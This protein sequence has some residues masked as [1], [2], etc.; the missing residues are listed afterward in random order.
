MENIQ[1]II[2]MSH[3][4]N[5]H[6]KTNKLEEPEIIKGAISPNIQK[7]SSLTRMINFSKPFPQLAVNNWQAARISVEDKIFQKTTSPAEDDSTDAK[8]LQG[9]INNH[10]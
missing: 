1:Q 4:E 10:Q 5:N 3:R 6:A 9:M 8:D 2:T 7:T